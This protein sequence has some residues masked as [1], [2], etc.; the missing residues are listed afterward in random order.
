MS[1]AKAVSGIHDKYG[2]KSLMQATN[3]QDIRVYHE[4][5]ENNHVVHPKGRKS[6]D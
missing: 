5:P 3:I 1:L 2:A 6:K 4:D